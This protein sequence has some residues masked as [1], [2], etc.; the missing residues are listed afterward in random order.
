MKYLKG[1]KEKAKEAGSLAKDEVKEGWKCCT[2]KGDGRDR[3]IAM[4]LIPIILTLVLWPLVG[5]FKAFLWNEHWP[6]P[7]TACMLVHAVQF[8]IGSLWYL[9]QTWRRGFYC[10]GIP[11]KKPKRIHPDD[12]EEGV[13]EESSGAAAKKAPM[14]P[15]SCA[16]RYVHWGFFPGLFLDIFVYAT[17]VAG[18]MCRDNPNFCTVLFR[19]LLFASTLIFLAIADSPRRGARL[20]WLM[21]VM[22]FFGVSLFLWNSSRGFTISFTTDLQIAICGLLALISFSAY[23]IMLRKASLDSSVMKVMYIQA[24]WGFIGMLLLALVFE[25]STP[26]H[27]AYVR[28]GIFTVDVNY[29]LMW[30]ITVIVLI[31]VCWQWAILTAVTFTE[32][33]V[34]SMSL[35]FALFLGD[36]GVHGYIGS[37]Y[38]F[39]VATIIGIILL[40]IPFLWLCKR[41]ITL[42]CQDE[43]GKACACCT[44]CSWCDEGSRE[45]G[46]TLLFDGTHHDEE[47]LDL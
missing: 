7:L 36:F 43:F 16:M 11:L 31:C 27:A 4:G 41:L 23:P 30:K 5:T 38:S 2:R 17:V 35:H 6:Y 9:K 44:C 45:E 40:G 47:L 14:T 10:L 39:S 15:L 8:I 42:N 13:E 34:V 33:I 19:S 3:S 1:M 12:I 46:S 20:D 29:A 22:M 18:P 24:T 37:G 26:W 32:T 28:T 25:G 21:A